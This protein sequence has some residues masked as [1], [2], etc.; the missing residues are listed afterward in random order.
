[1]MRQNLKLI[2]VLLTLL[3][4]LSTPTIAAD[5]KSKVMNFVISSAPDSYLVNLTTAVL[6]N[7]F[8]RMGYGYQVASY[9]QK[10]SIWLMQRGEVDGDATRVYN[11]NRGN[12]H[13]SYVRVEENIASVHWDAFATDPKIKV[14][15]WDDLK[16]GGYR[17][18]YLAGVKYNEQ[19]LVGFIEERKLVAQPLTNINGLKQLMLGRTDVYIYPDGKEAYRALESEELKTSGIVFAGRVDTVKIYPY[20]H[21]K[22]ANLAAAVAQKIKELKDEGLFK[23]YQDQALAKM[24][25]K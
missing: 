23:K 9:P 4:V 20:L 16:K 21:K 24:R 15:S 22:H 14:S 2:L 10:R 25:R 7:V 5:T 3:P 6:K 8:S 17:V 19:H 1:M 11:F 13:P 18:G 12:M